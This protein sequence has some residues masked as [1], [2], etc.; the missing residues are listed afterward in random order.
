MRSGR[1]FTHLP[2]SQSA[3]GPEGR[4][5][6]PCPPRLARKLELP[7]RVELCLSTPGY[8]TSTFASSQ[9]EIASPLP[10]DLGP[11]GDGLRRPASARFP[12]PQ[13]QQPSVRFSPFEHSAMRSS[14][15]R[16]VRAKRSGSRSAAAAGMASCQ[17]AA[18][19][20]SVFRTTGALSA[21]DGSSQWRFPVTAERPSARC[22]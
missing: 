3:K 17:S 7:L 22:F 6:G 19:A 12:S 1:V 9:L 4:H 18:L 21:P 14:Q 11:S 20:P 5:A 8:R 2:L 16:H 15:R 10:A 13:A